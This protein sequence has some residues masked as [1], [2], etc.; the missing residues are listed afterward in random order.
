[1]LEQARFSLARAGVMVGLCAVVVL[2]SGWVLNHREAV[3]SKAPVHFS[4]RTWEEAQWVLGLIAPGNST[5][6][7]QTPEMPAPSC[8]A[9]R[10]D[11]ERLRKA[12]E[13]LNQHLDQ[14]AQSKFIKQQY[15]LNPTT[16]FQAASRTGKSCAEMLRPVQ[17]LNERVRRQGVQFLQSLLWKERLAGVAQSRFDTNT[18]VTLPKQMLTSRSAWSGLPGCVYGTDA[19]TGQRVVAE[20]GDSAALKF[21]QAQVA[22]NQALRSSESLWACTRLIVVDG[23][24]VGLASSPAQLVQPTRG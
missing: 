8:A 16:L 20:R 2:G 22:A 13:V 21:C 3:K 4:V 11:H 5:H 7:G 19:A 12:V 15:F 23:A 10:P 9:G 24:H 17:W 18:W 6:L 1:M 14:L